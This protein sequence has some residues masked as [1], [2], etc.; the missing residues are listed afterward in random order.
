MSW[1]TN[2]RIT[3]N[4]RNPSNGRKYSN[5]R[6]H[7]VST[8]ATSSNWM[9]TAQDGWVTNQPFDWGPSHQEQQQQQATRPV[10]RRELKTFD[11]PKTQEIAIDCEMV[12]ATANFKR[13]SVLARVSIVNSNCQPLLDTYVDPMCD[14]SDYRTA[15]SG[16][17]PE[18]LRGAPTYENVRQHVIE[19]LGHG[20]ILIGHDLKQDLDVL[21][22]K[23][24]PRYRLRD[25]SRCYLSYFKPNEKPSLK[26]LAEAVLGQ[27]IQIG[28]H[29]SLEDARVAMILWKHWDAL[30]K[31]LEDAMPPEGK[32][33]KNNRNNN[34]K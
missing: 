29:N 26:R 24:I 18:H 27:T 32:Q 25:T 34:L 10:R 13:F 2:G 12:E 31:N 3:S 15:Y 16:I 1:T 21:G 17:L 4:G 7:Q 33:K 19:L 23:H 5:G 9:H 6:Y 8:N 11:H 22:I 30:G 28:A 20:R 14:V